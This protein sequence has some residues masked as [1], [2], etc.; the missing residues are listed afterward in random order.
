MSTNWPKSWF[1]SRGSAFLALLLLAGVA[2]AQPQDMPGMKPQNEM[3]CQCGTGMMLL[4][5]LV[6]VAAVAAL[7][8]LTIFLVRRSRPAK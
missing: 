1:L 6:A 2:I 5:G 3:M 8:A 7:I 4:G